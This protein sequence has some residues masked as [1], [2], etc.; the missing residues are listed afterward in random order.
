MKVIIKKGMVLIV[1]ISVFVNLAACQFESKVNNSGSAYEQQMEVTVANANKEEV[2]ISKE[3]YTELA[4]EQY[5]EN[6]GHKSEVE[7]NNMDD[8]QLED[9]STDADKKMKEVTSEGSEYEEKVTVF[10]DSAEYIGFYKYTYENSTDTLIED[11]YMVINYI[12]GQLT[13]RYYGTSDEF[14]EAREG[15]YPGFFVLDMVDLNIDGRSISFQLELTENQ[16]FTYP[17]DVSIATSEGVN[18][19]NNPLWCNSHITGSRT[20]SGKVEEDRILILR[21]N[22][23]RIFIKME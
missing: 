3:S 9:D 1:F 2:K 18:L 8:E 14:D 21:E 16:I 11:H 12:E 5:V 6:D 20:Y 15:Y 19:D 17:I 13:G 22:D 10:D 7:V 4:D 23:E